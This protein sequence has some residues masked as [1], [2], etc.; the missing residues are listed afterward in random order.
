MVLE[1]ADA[2]RFTGIPATGARV[3]AGSNRVCDLVL[4][5][6]RVRA[7]HFEAWATPEGVAVHDPEDKTLIGG[8]RIGRAV[9]PPGARLVL[10]DSVV[11][12]VASAVSDDLRSRLGAEGLA[13]R[14]PRMVEVA[15]SVQRVAPFTATVLLEG[16][17]GTGKEVV[18]RAIHR[19]SMRANGPLVIV[20]C[21]ALPASVLE[22][23]LFGHERGAF[24]GADRLRQ[25]AFERA[26]GGTLML[27]E[28]GELPLSSQPALLGV[29][30]RRRFRRVGGH[31]EVEVD[32]RVV[33]A[34][35]KDLRAEVE[36][37]AFRADLYYRLCGAHLVLP[38]LRLRPEDLP[39]LI[40]HILAELT[41]SAASSP[42]DARALAALSAHPWPGNVRELRSVVER[43]VMTGRL[44][45]AGA[46]VSEERPAASPTATVIPAPPD[47]DSPLATY[48]AA[49][50]EALEGFEHGYLRRLIETC[51]GNASE[52]A[53]VARMDCPHLVKLLRR[54][55]LR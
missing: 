8:L 24:T 32:V 15:E 28:I 13:F 42:F 9:V 53:R 41:G 18:A 16:E 52:A 51:H 44:D 47:G 46:R 31:A 29:L 49:R 4:H 33:A 30:Q 35:N 3:S 36:R 5:D 7:L 1:G 19:M 34:T 6:P 10:G 38:P 23:E 21:G 50:A 14:G 54:R 17:T 48:R 40:E 45:F 39:I 27:D 12:I 26:H 2:G 20:D 25:G 43:A 37:G 11:G 22:S 55:G